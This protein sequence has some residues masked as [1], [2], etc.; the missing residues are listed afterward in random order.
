[1]AIV[2][3]IIIIVIII[4]VINKNKKT[5][6]VIFSQNQK[7]TQLYASPVTIVGDLLN[8]YFKKKNIQ[9]TS[10][11]GFLCGGENLAIDDNKAKEVGKFIPKNSDEKEIRIIVN[12]FSSFS[13]SRELTN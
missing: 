4:I 7:V 12:D 5:I 8:K 1:M 11:I 2:V 10:K 3:V 13:S 9:N 6:K